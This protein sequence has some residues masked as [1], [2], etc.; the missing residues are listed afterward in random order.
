MPPVWSSR[1]AR[2]CRLRLRRPA[3]RCIAI[4]IRGAVRSVTANRT[5]EAVT[6][7]RRI[8]AETPRNE[9]AAPA[10]AADP[11]RDH[12]QPCRRR[13][14]DGAHDGGES[15]RR[16]G[17][18]SGR[19]ASSTTARV[20]APAPFVIRCGMQ[21][22]TLRRPTR[23]PAATSAGPH[24]SPRPAPSTRPTI[25]PH[26]VRVAR[27]RKRMN[28][29]DHARVHP[30]HHGHD[31]EPT[32]SAFSV[33][34]PYRPLPTHRSTNDSLATSTAAP[35]GPPRPGRARPGE[36]GPP[37]VPARPSP[38]SR[39]RPGPPRQQLDERPT[40]GPHDE[41][42]RPEHSRGR[43]A[44]DGTHEHELCAEQQQARQVTEREPPAAAGELTQLQ[45]GRTLDADPGQPSPS[46]DPSDHVADQD[47][48]HR[49]HD[50]S[51]KPESGCHGEQPGD[52]A[53]QQHQCVDTDADVVEIHAAEHERRCREQAIKRDRCHRHEEHDTRRRHQVTRN[54]H[55]I[56]QREGSQ[57]GDHRDDRQRHR[58]DGQRR[59]D[60]ATLGPR[61]ARC[62][63]G[64]R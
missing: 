34:P 42:R 41:L 22:S 53:G 48:E 46:D 51:D 30:D 8:V 4:G 64:P 26:S 31:R 63:S 60:L 32:R 43:R 23:S 20:R 40:H 58:P 39:A 24:C 15:E 56:G 9:K 10:T 59:A 25:E 14:D 33:A 2:S 13:I 21:T 29:V 6:R 45:R 52:A 37:T 38:A 27:P 28:S 61:S 44:G 55:D 50:V 54:V 57:S 3:C 5:P 19:N 11:N 1:P 36:R 7:S 16:C 49:S 17:R 62:A 12:R 18:S 47:P 35:T